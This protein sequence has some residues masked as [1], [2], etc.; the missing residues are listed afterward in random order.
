MKLSPGDLLFFPVR[1]YG[2]LN[3][4]VRR[5]ITWGH[6]AIYYTETK[7]G[8]PLII[9]SVG[10]GVLIR[11]LYC[12]TGETVR[13]MRPRDADAG[14]RAAKAAERLADNPASWYGY[15]DIPRYVVP[16]L[17]LAKLDEWLPY[18]LK[19]PLW[20][21]AHTYRRNSLY[22]CSEL[23]ADAYANAGYPLVH[24]GTIALPDD[25]AA[26]YRLIS[27]GDMEVGLCRDR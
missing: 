21:L 3:P 16:K 5:L 24:E 1:G 25:L 6:V 12:Y 11:T 26:S 20:L 19:L 4:I 7:R 15:Y 23:V 18:L 14:L 13:V 17:V 10:R 27:L 8:L 9:E 22:I 2:V